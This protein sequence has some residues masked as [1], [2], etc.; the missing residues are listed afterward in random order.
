VDERRRFGGA[1]SGAAGQSDGQPQIP[2]PPTTAGGLLALPDPAAANEALPFSGRRVAFRAARRTAIRAARLSAL[3][4]A[5][6]TAIRAARRSALRAA[7]RT[8][9]RAARRSAPRAEIDAA[10]N[11]SGGWSLMVGHEPS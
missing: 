11:A 5:R 1:E 6:R 4:A 7:R 8:A 9:S 2:G 3:R 10:P